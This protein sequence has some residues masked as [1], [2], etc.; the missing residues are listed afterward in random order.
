MSIGS[1]LE[2]P[3]N[4]WTTNEQFFVDALIASTAFQDI[5]DATTGPGTVAEKT[6][7]HVFLEEAPRAG[8]DYTIEELESLRHYA[9]VTSANEGGYSLILGNTEYHEPTGEV[10][11]VIRRLIKESERMVNAPGI[12]MRWFK[13]RIGDF[14]GGL[15]AYAKSN[16]GPVIQNIVVE[17]GPRETAEQAQTTQGFWLTCHLAISWAFNLE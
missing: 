10:E 14:M 3:S 2:A 5:V 17:F 11:V 12:P 1:T 6:A 7:S 13:N 4:C 15:Q 8:T 16:G 9:I